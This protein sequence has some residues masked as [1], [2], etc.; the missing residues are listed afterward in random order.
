MERN[1][2]PQLTAN[3][4]HKTSEWFQMICDA[5][6]CIFQL[7]LH[8]LQSRVKT[9]P[10]FPVDLQ[11]ECMSTITAKH[12]LVWGDLLLC[13]Y[14]IKAGKKITK[15]CWMKEIRH[16]TKDTILVLAQLIYGEQS[17]NNVCLDGGN[18][19]K[20]HERIFLGNV[21]S[22]YLVCGSS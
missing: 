22:C 7:R 18:S 4:N 9:T 5:C 6:L 21:N 8:K 16:E 15:L 14:S 19:R 2:G 13:T 10:L 3:H 20:E 12:H 11:R 1:W 17:L